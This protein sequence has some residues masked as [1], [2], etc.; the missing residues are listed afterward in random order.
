MAELW[1]IDPDQSYR[2]LR[3]QAMTRPALLP[4]SFPM[5]AAT[6][7]ELPHAVAGMFDANVPLVGALLADAS[8]AGAW[9]LGLHVK[10]GKELA[11]ALTAG[12]DASYAGRLDGASGVFLL[13]PKAKK[14]S[15]FALGIVNNYLL[16]AERAPVLPLA[17]PFVARTLPKRPVPTESIV[18]TA[19][20]AALSGPV[21]K[22]LHRLWREQAAEL[23]TLDQKNRQERGGR[24]PDFGDPLA[25]LNGVG[26]AVDALSDV[27]KS[28][29]ELRAVIEPLDDGLE[30][31]VELTPGQ[32]GPAAEVVKELVV[33]GVEPLLLLPKSTLLGVLTRGSPSQREESAK[34]MSARLRALFGDRLS[35]SDKKLIDETLAQLARG[36]GD[37]G[38]YALVERGGGLCGVMRGATGDAG[39]FNAGIKS[40]LKFPRVRAFSEP[41]RQFVGELTVRP[42][43]ASVP[44][45][46]GVTDRAALS[47]KPA[48]IRTA[49][50]SAAA[51]EVESFEL[52]WR[53]DTELLHAAVCGEAAPALVELIQ[54]VPE[55]SLASEPMVS[56]A[57]RRA[58]PVS[59]A[60]VLRPL[61]LSATDDPTLDRSAPVFIAVGRE[62][63]RM[64]LLARASKAV[65]S[66]LFQG[67]FEP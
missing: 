57:A 33:G 23:K 34:S 16:V 61:A 36:R 54:A 64:R 17:G 38:A 5:L 22:Q 51:L 27:L 25:A 13:E 45:L 59:F 41:L 55:R 30:L 42:S 12:A 2:K 46:P 60:A 40:L 24:A 37:F 8:G 18:L 43:S 11:A 7:L 9:V 19:R 21:P 35:E 58:G 39:A 44:G 31:R 29:R 6:L 62:G 53:A 47:I 67:A 4:A 49:G 48:R 26:A 32:E 10:S 3:E 50:A 15:T 14:D 63:S 66:R 56:A 52:L 65:T 1:V 28:A 20:Q